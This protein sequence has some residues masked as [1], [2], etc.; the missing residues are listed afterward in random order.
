MP[1]IVAL[2]LCVLLVA[3]PLVIGEIE[4]VPELTAVGYSVLVGVFMAFLGYL[5]TNP[6]EAFSPE[7]FVTTPVTGVFAGV[8]MAFFKVDY[9]AAMT[10][11]ATAGALALIEFVGKA[12]VRRLW[13]SPPTAKV[14]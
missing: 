6:L 14:G 5:K 2:L 7:L 9:A 8:V 11:L 3:A 12:V 10:W 4:D 13:A 1:A